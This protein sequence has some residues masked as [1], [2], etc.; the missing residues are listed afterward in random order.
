MFYGLLFTNFVNNR[1]LLNSVRKL[2][3]ETGLIVFEYI[4]R[5][6]LYDRLSQQQPSCYCYGFNAYAQQLYVA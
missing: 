2:E 1:Q 5:R 4:V 6:I 3:T